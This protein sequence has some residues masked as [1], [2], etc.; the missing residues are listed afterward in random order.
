MSERNQLARSVRALAAITG[1]EELWQQRTADGESDSD[2]WAFIDWLDAGKNRGA[3]LAKHQTTAA[4]WGWAERA[5]AYERASDLQ[6]GLVPGA[7]G[8]REISCDNLERMLQIETTKLMRQSATD[9]NPVVG[10]KDLLATATLLRDIQ[11]KAI[12][13]KSQATDLSKFT[14][15]ELRQIMAT[16]ALMRT[17]ATTK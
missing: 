17:K 5:I 12:Q 2:Y 10:V 14:P 11:L 8:P 13:E 6:A 16:Q 3:P 1:L 7:K 4:R 15:D 9:P